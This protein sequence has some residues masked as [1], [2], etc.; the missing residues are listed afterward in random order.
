MASDLSRESHFADGDDIFD[1]HQLVNQAFPFRRQR[2]CN[3]AARVQELEAVRVAEAHPEADVDRS[4]RMLHD[5]HQRSGAVFQAVDEPDPL[6]GFEP[7]EPVVVSA[8]QQV[9]ADPQLDA[10]PEIGPEETNGKGDNGQEEDNRLNR[11]TKRF[12]LARPTCCEA[13][14]NEIDAH[15][16]EGYGAVNGTV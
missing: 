15:T 8:R 3:R 5:V 11:E 10:M 14:C 7:I 2:I 6:R 1:V 12:P 16:K 4:Q 13:G 9:A